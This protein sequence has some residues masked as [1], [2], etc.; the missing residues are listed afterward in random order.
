MNCLWKSVNDFISVSN[1][2]DIKSHGKLIKGEICKNGYKRIH[3]S[4][5][6][7]DYKILV[8]RLVAEAFIPNPENKPCIN[9]IDGNKQNNCVE[10]LE[11]CTYSENNKHAYKKGLKS[12]KGE[13]N[14]MSKLTKNDVEFIRTHCVKN[15]KEFGFV[16][17]GKRFGV[18]PKTIEHAYKGITWYF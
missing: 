5:K 3:V 8:H 14:G 18:N 11:W 10:N 6:G 16:A 7:I 2:G 12:A 15:S 17:L 13:R 4:H 9:H 1:Y